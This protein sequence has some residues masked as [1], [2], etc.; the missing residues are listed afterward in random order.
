MRTASRSTIST[1]P[2]RNGH[3]GSSRKA[4]RRGML[5]VFSENERF[6]PVTR[7]SFFTTDSVPGR[8]W[9]SLKELAS[10]IT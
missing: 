3:A 5:A 2:S 10:Q 1:L 6:R 8:G 4:G 9:T 7:D